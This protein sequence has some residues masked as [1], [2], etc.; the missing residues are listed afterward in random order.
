SNEELMQVALVAVARP[1]PAY[2]VVRAI[3]DHVLANAVAGHDLALPPG[4]CWLSLVGLHL[5]IRRVPVLAE[6]HELPLVV[7]D[8][9]TVLPGALLRGDKDVARS[10]VLRLSGYLDGG[11]AKLWARAVGSHLARLRRG[12]MVTLQILITPWH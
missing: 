8:H 5:E 2:L 9:R 4:Q 7:D 10:S 11:R 12:R 6:P 1:D 3:E